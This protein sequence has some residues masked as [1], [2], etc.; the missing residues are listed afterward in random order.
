MTAQS[1]ERRLQSSVV[2]VMSA[3]DGWTLM[4]DFARRAARSI[5]TG[6]RV[7]LSVT[8]GLVVVALFGC[9]NPGRVHVVPLN[10]AAIDPPAARVTTINLHDCYWWTS[11]NGEVWI[12]MEHRRPVPIAN[13]GDFVFRMSLVLESLP[14]G[15]SR[16]YEA[17][18]RE[19][20]ALARFG[21]AESRF[22]SIKG[23]VALYREGEDR[24]RGSFRL[25]TIRQVSQIL[26][27]WSKP[28]R[29]LMTGTFNARKDPKRGREILEDT[30][31]YGWDRPA[32]KPPS[33]TQPA[34]P[35]SR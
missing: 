33:A 16:N 24:L 2:D 34:K 25:L 28:T 19:L 14:A 4:R 13:T 23:I 3:A 9:V 6:L 20:R 21:P 18:R 31:R 5:A 29:H 12:A 26:G 27:G 30:E 17:S 22:E 10:Y 32:L 11:E 35:Q 15:R 7:C 1:A 8:L